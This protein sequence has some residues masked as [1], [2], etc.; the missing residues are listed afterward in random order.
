MEVEREKPL[1]SSHCS[2]TQKTKWFKFSLSVFLHV[3]L[4]YPET[5]SQKKYV[6]ELLRPFS[7]NLSHFQRQTIGQ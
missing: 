7:F 3:F 1:H 2:Q 5:I 6:L 4:S